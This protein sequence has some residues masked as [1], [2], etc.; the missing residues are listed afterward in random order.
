MRL[1]QPK[2]SY[3]A[4]VKASLLFAASAALFLVAKTTGF[5]PKWPWSEGEESTELTLSETTVGA[6][7][8]ETISL[9]VLQETSP[10]IPLVEI[11]DAFIGS[12]DTD[13]GLLELDVSNPSV[14]M[15]QSTYPAD[16]G[17]SP[18]S[19]ES[20]PVDLLVTP[21]EEE[22]DIIVVDTDQIRA[23]S[24]QRR[25]LQASSPVTV[26]NPIPNQVIDASQQYSYIL[27]S[28]FSP[29]YEY[30][31][32]GVLP[33]WL[34]LQYGFSGSAVT[35]G[36]AWDVVIQNNIAFVAADSSD[37]VIVDI[38]TPS[39]PML[40][41]SLSLAGIA[42]AIAVQNGVA[43]I[44]MKTPSSLQF[45]NIS[46]PRQPALLGSLS[47]TA[48]AQ[49]VVWNGAIAVVAANSSG[50]VLVSTTNP[51]TPTLSGRTAAGQHE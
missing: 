11:P 46:N 43:A 40:L 3:S 27:N 16:S 15:L 7:L 48:S 13:A 31:S 10:S 44:A 41:A 23:Q 50:L 29:G 32:A 45:V 9:S 42:D 33:S 8:P 34:N 37:L 19:I 22:D 24:T 47:L 1:E 14:P 28:V 21:V 17:E 51:S 26:K 2:T 6:E 39:Q 25:L 30:L 20:D 12:Y 49:D 38:T 36:L 35:T 5:L 18:L 4:Y